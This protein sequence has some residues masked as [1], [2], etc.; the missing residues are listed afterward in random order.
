MLNK[1]IFQL[2]KE[3][4]PTLCDAHDA[5][6]P[7]T[8]ACSDRPL[9][10]GGKVEMQKIADIEKRFG[11]V[12]H[13]A[14]QVPRDVRGYFYRCA[15]IDGSNSSKQTPEQM[16]VVEYFE[17]LKKSE[18]TTDVVLCDMSKAVGRGVFANKK[19]KRG[20]VICLYAGE[21]KEFSADNKTNLSYAIR[22]SNPIFSPI[23]SIQAGK[24]VAATGVIDAAKYRNTGAFLQHLPAA[25]DL[26]VLGVPKQ[27]HPH[28][29]TAN[30]EIVEVEYRGCPTGAVLALRDIEKDEQ[31]GWS[32]DDSDHQKGYWN[33][34]D[35]FYLFDMKGQ[36]F[37]QVTLPD[38]NMVSLADKRSPSHGPLLKLLPA[39]QT[40]L[41]QPAVDAKK[42]GDYPAAI[43]LFHEAI[44][45]LVKLNQKDPYI[46]Q[47]IG[48]CYHKIALCH[49][50]MGAWWKAVEAEANALAC[51][52]RALKNEAE[53]PHRLPALEKN[54]G[55]LKKK[56]TADRQRYQ[57]EII[58]RS[59][60]RDLGRSL[61]YVM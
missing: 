5:V 54:L 18:S 48:N 21:L 11:I 14:M 60:V 43:K 44:E 27:L 31:L 25:K 9:P 6:Q 30:A 4:N 56:S 52:E 34:G 3:R 7:K 10:Q 50:E 22:I 15:A 28:I 46:G 61:C 16:A 20:D 59:A 13:E 53:L 2:H 37:I 12:W 42:A 23:S 47:Y 1:S 57:N 8:V 35:N 58:D 45:T 29:A 19:F 51:C 55:E 26:E 39:A 49:A 41:V 17:K 40:M 36:E 24:D 32:Y 33:V 38:G